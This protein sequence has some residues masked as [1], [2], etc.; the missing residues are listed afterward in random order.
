VMLHFFFYRLRR[1]SGPIN[2]KQFPL[3]NG[4]CGGNDASQ[5]CTQ[6]G[7]NTCK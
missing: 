2:V 3:I 1:E 6:L 7:R 4:K 5:V